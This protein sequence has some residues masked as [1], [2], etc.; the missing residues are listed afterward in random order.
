MKL[1]D[2]QQKKV[3]GWIAEGLKISEIQKRLEL[4][5]GLRMTYMEV[6]FLV[7]D[8][9]LTPRDIEP[10]KPI[11]PSLKGP[12]TKPPSEPPAAQPG[13]LTE[14]SLPGESAAGASRVSVTVDTV[15]QPGALVSGSV[16]FS[17]GQTAAWYLDQMGRLG[18]APKKQ[19]YRPAQA[20]VEAFQLALQ[21]ELAKL[22]L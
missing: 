17:D 6:R 12:S 5:C 3:T 22:G 18:L 1:D 8:L 16:N 21:G 4:E 20:D 13:G 2:A 14:K 15:T 10:P 9:K 11:V 19:G 7:D